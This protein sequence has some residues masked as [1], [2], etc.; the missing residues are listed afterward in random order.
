VFSGVHSDLGDS[1]LEP[2]SG[3]SKIALEWMLVEASSMACLSIPS[4]RRSYLVIRDQRPKSSCHGTSDLAMKSVGMNRGGAGG[5]V[6]E[7]ADS[8]RLADP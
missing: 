3:L 1:Y 5:W 6:S 8:A 7:T 2:S 4:E